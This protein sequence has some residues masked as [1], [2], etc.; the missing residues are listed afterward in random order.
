[1]DRMAMAFG[2]IS[3]VTAFSH[4][5]GMTF[6]EIQQEMRKKLNE[7]IASHN[8]TLSHI[9]AQEG[10][11]TAAFEAF[12]SLVLVD[13]AEV[14]A[15]VAFLENAKTEISEFLTQDTDYIVMANAPGGVQNPDETTNT[16]Y[17]TAL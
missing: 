10:D 13:V 2:P 11:W 8:N 6:L 12:K 15:L 14:Q 1:M 17:T 9:K 16:D 4:R 7:L 3:D 5:A